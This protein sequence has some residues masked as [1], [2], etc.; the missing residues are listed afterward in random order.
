MN[1]NEQK[2]LPPS[3]S[4]CS[5]TGPNRIRIFRGPVEH[6]GKMFNSEKLGGSFATWHEKQTDTVDVRRSFAV[7][8]QIEFRQIPAFLAAWK[9]LLHCATSYQRKHKKLSAAQINSISIC[10]SLNRGTSSV[11]GERG[12][13]RGSRKQKCDGRSLFSLVH[14]S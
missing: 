3:I 4:V 11:T 13:Q 8:V 10:R 2:V 5:P 14:F 12:I 6:G 1:I 7:S 9:M